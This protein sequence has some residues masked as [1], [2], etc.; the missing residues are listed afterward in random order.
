MDPRTVIFDRSIERLPFTITIEAKATP[1]LPE[2]NSDGRSLSAYKIRKHCEGSLKR[3][4]TDWI[5]LYQMHCWDSS[6][7]LEE[8]LRAHPIDGA[9]LLGGCDKSTPALVMGAVS[10]GLPFIF[11]L[12]PLLTGLKPLLGVALSLTLVLTGFASQDSAIEAVNLAMMAVERERRAAA[13]AAGGCAGPPR[14]R[15]RTAAGS[16]LIPDLAT[17]TSGGARCRRNGGGVVVGLNLH[18]DMNI[19]LV[20]PIDTGLR[21]REEALDGATG[22]RVKQRQ[23]GI[24]KQ[25]K[26]QNIVG[27]NHQRKI[28]PGEQPG[29]MYC[30]TGGQQRHHCCCL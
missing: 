17:R 14:P 11:F 16:A 4:Q 2:V 10:M 24:K 25:Y 9:V 13:A 5:D 3:M 20:V 23:R 30:S 29:F 19:F 26:S 12:L 18:Q 22:H 6:T 7:P 15:Q 8:T 27:V 21:V 28:Q 1:N